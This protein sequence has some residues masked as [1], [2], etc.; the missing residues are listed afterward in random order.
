MNTIISTALAGLFVW[1]PMASTTPSTPVIEL[2]TYSVSMTAY[3]AV[4]GQTDDTPDITASGAFSNPELIAARSRD[5]ADELPFGTVIEVVAADASNNCGFEVV[6]NQIG[7]R[8][9]GDTM[10][11][12]MVNKIDILFDTTDTARAGGKI[13][14]SARVLGRCTGVEIRVVG[15]IDIRNMPKSQQALR[16]AMGILEKADQ[17][18]L[19][20]KK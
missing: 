18:N 10:N 17:Q 16:V 7:L 2:P 8:V 5:L 6:K 9:I 15:K 1:T 13:H 20:I 4:P 11:A 12:R 19:A 14:N 3:N